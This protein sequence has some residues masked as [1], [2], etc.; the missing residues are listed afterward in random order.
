M[1]V[2]R[3]HWPEYAIEAA[4][5]GYFMIAACVYTALI[6][7]P[8]FAVRHVVEGDM[9]RRALVGLSMGLT[10]ISIV[11]S[12]WGKRSG[13][14]I[15]P[16]VTFTF[17][18]LGKIDPRD[19]VFYIGAQVSGAV[20]GVMIA[21]LLLGPIVADESVHYAVT[22]IGPW[23]TAAAFLA[24]VAISFVLMS[25]VLQVSNSRFERWTGLVAGTLVALYITF[26]APISGMSMNPARSLGSAVSA[27]F[28]MGQWIYLVAPPLG[29][30]LAS[31]AFV[32]L[33]GRS[34]V[35]CAKLHHA[36]SQRCIF[37]EYRETRTRQ[38]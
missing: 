17:F 2:M 4:A 18:R 22:K 35:W 14:H 1:D 13:A 15:N 5:L 6:E 29:M 20:L 27:G 24:E 3:R 19:A 31:E 8:A 7:H 36:N 30:F 10:A 38:S 32:R 21:A 34:A 33:R 26:E 12:P 37:C 11:Y 23:G 16:S 28:W 25:A 9:T